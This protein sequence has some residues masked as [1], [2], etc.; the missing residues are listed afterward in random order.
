[1]RG[2]ALE[3]IPMIL[4]Q[5]SASQLLLAI[6]GRC[7]WHCAF[8]FRFASNFRSQRRGQIES[9]QLSWSSYTLGLGLSRLVSPRYGAARN[10]E[11]IPSIDRRNREGQVSQFLLAETLAHTFIHFVRYVPLLNVRHGFGPGEGSP[12]TI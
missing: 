5:D 1:M 7:S 8:R 9:R 2:S 10:I 3:F 6:P 12:F 11:A 4:R